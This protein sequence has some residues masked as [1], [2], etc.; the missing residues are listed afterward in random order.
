[1]RPCVT[2]VFFRAPSCGKMVVGDGDVLKTRPLPIELQH[3]V[4]G[5]RAAGFRNMRGRRRIL[6]RPQSDA[7]RI[8]DHLVASGRRTGNMT[9]R[10]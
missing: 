6:V 2:M 9:V 4:A 8:D 1:M 3:G 7:A 10:A 5:N